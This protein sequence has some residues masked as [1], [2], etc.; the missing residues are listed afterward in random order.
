M[1]KVLYSIAIV[2]SWL[3]EFFSSH[4]H[5]YTARY[6]KLHEIVKILIHKSALLEKYPVFFLAIGQFD[7]LYCVL[8][9]KRQKE[10][11]NVIIYGK[12]RI[13]KGL[14]FETNL[15]TWSFPAM[16]NDIK[17]ELWW[18]TAGFREKGLG[19][20]SLKFDPRGNGNKFDPMEGLQTDSDFRSAAT[21]LLYRPNLGENAVFTERAITMLTQIFIAAWLEGYRV[22]PYTYFVLNEGLSGVAETL[23]R[24]TQKY[25]YYPNL[26]TKFLDVTYE[27][28]KKD[29]FSSRFLNDCYSTMTAR[30]N[31]IL[32]KE[33]VKC[34][35]GSDFTAKDIMTSGEN[36]IS[37]YFCWPEKNL[38]SLSPIIQLVWDSLINGMTDY[39]DSVRGE[40]CYRV[41]AFLDEIF[42][43]GMPQ[44][45]KY[46]TTVCG[47]DISLFITAQNRAQLD[48]EFGVFKANELRGQIDSIIYHRPA[49][50]DYESMAH[51]ER[52]LGYTSAFAH[53]KNEHVGGTSTGESEQRIPLMPTHESELIDDT[54]VIVKRSGIRATIARRLNWHEFPELEQR[55]K[56]P[57][58]DVHSLVSSEQSH[59]EFT[60]WG[61]Q[62]P[63]FLA[64]QSSR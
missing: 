45:P 32:T 15:L 26:A 21:I 57:P 40:G 52:L 7:Q 2:F 58:P 23:E 60:Q 51:I 13:G 22:L 11:G 39:Y 49:P 61:M 28:A 25:N 6:A 34:F 59:N 64:E 5:I 42:R 41:G 30:L 31:N 53:S 50:D 3:F 18:R 48:A 27:K 17:E 54:Q 8:P 36:P 14:N 19:G 12:S 33:S 38:L 24:I 35:I 9:T 56:I 1:K 16:I 20:K 62:M 10:L 46:A 4:L 44:L 55:S 47:R 29:D 63:I 43:T 37:V